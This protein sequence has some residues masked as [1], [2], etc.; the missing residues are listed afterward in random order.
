MAQRFLGGIFGNTAPSTAN[1]PTTSGVYDLKGQY[2]VKQEGGWN[3]PLSASGGN[4][5]D[6]STFPGKSVHV[7]TTPGNFVVASGSGAV[8]VLLVG[9]GGGGGGA[10]GG[11]GGGGAYLPTPISVGPGTYPIT[12]GPAGTP[13]Q[14][15][16][17]HFGTN[18]WPGPPTGG[19]G[20]QGIIV[21]RYPT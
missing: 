3:D 15:G 20:G 9:G 4:T 19:A 10:Y 12:V 6:T 16:G 7:F 8:E 11:G 14:D 17:G 2:Y 21:I 1:V 13:G 18:A 5:T